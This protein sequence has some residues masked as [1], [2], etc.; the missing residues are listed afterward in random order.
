MAVCIIAARNGDDEE[1][2]MRGYPEKTGALT[3]WWLQQ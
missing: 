3:S 2:E 1:R